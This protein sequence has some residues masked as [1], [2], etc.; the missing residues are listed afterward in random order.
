MS[1][2]SKARPQDLRGSPIPLNA[3]PPPRCSTRVVWSTGQARTVTELTPEQ[4]AALFQRWDVDAETA[5]RL[6]GAPYRTDL[7]CD[8]PLPSLEQFLRRLERHKAIEPRMSWW[9]RA[10]QSLV[11][12]FGEDLIIAAACILIA[13][14]FV[15]RTI[16]TFGGAA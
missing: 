13:A 2:A 15:G 3:P 14:F 5:E 16:W 10:F 6:C 4:A 11:A 1:R 9:G 7:Y 12:R 8:Q